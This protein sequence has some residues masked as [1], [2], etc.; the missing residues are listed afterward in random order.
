MTQAKLANGRVPTSQETWQAISGPQGNPKLTELIKSGQLI[1]V[2]NPPEEGL[3][4]YDK[5]APTMGGWVLMHSEPRR[6]T[7]QEFA[8]LSGQ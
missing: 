2:P 7:A 3:W 8:Q 1:L 6:V 5:D 4:A